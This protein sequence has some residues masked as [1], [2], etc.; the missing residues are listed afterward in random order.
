MIRWLL[1]RGA[2]VHVRDVNNETPLLSAVRAGHMA[3][4]RTLAQCGAH[5]D[6][7]PAQVRILESYLIGGFY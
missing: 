4:V 1:G 6:L 5:L 2:S 7:T 3:V